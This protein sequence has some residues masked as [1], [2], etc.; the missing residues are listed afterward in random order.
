MRVADVE[1][2]GSWEKMLSDIEHQRIA[3]E[4]SMKAIGVYT[5]QVTQKE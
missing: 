1:M 4:T 3:P 2:T 5:R